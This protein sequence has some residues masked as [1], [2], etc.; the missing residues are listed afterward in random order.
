MHDIKRAY[1]VG[2]QTA[3]GKL[4]ILIVGLR[5]DDDKTKIFKGRDELR[6]TRI[7]V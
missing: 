5:Q 6:E 1:S 3:D 2:K 4:P 7:R